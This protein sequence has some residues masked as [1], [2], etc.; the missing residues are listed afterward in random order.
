MKQQNNIFFFKMSHREETKG[1]SR[2]RQRRWR[3]IEG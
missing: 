2:D 1:Q 3:A